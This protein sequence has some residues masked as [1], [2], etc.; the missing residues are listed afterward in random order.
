M[1]LNS[2]KLFLKILLSHWPLCQLG[3]PIKPGVKVF[4]GACRST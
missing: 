4:K 3:K 2:K 1:D